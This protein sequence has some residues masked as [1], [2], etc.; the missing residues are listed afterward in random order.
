MPRRCCAATVFQGRE[1]DEPL[2]AIVIGIP[3]TTPFMPRERPNPVSAAYLGL[4]LALRLWRNAPP[5]AR[6]AR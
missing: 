6:A 1:L 5:S 2:D 3:P 4:G